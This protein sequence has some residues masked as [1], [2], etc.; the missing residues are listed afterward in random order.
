MLLTMW[1]TLDTNADPPVYQLQPITT[2]FPQFTSNVMPL[3]RQHSS[4]WWNEFD[5]LRDLIWQL[6]DI[7]FAEQRITLERSHVY[8]QSGEYI[9]ICSFHLQLTNSTLLCVHHACTCICITVGI[10]TNQSIT[11]AFF[12]CIPDSRQ[13][14]YYCMLSTM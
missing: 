14:F 8:K 7:A 3:R 12:V 4:M 5:K 1:Y 6:A 13:Y 2:Y 9:C 11:L 10:C